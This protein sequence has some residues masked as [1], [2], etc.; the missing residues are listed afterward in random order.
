V[1]VLI[2]NLKLEEDQNIELMNVIREISG[3]INENQE[4]AEGDVQP[5]IKRSRQKEKVKERKAKNLM[6]CHA[7]I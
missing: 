5:F 1:V 6:S 7:L 3:C 4:E 2:N